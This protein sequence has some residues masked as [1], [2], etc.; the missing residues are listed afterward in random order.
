MQ[1]TSDMG[2]KYSKLRNEWYNTVQDSTNKKKTTITHTHTHTKVDTLCTTKKNKRG[3][4]SS[5]DRWKQSTCVQRG[6]D[7]KTDCTVRGPI[8]IDRS[9][10]GF[11]ETFMPPTLS[12]RRGTA[13]MYVT[14][15]MWHTNL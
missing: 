12:K 5:K 7:R 6:L 11:V 3:F 14:C 2:D 15:L 1:R 4:G 9:K 10:E 13:S 8:M